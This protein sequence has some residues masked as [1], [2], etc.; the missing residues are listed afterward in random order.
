ME[1]LKKIKE[2]EVVQ[3]QSQINM[4]R[5]SLIAKDQE[6]KEFKANLEQEYERRSM[7]MIQESKAQN[8]DENLEKELHELR[9]K[10]TELEK[11]IFKK[12]KDIEYLVRENKSLS[13]E[14]GLKAGFIETMQLESCAAIED[15]KS[16]VKVL[17]GK[18]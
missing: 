10:F 8:P 15:E 1:H 16:K 17:M 3:Q 9:G 11:D 18:N 12:T 6:F 5:D 13:G 7:K 4:L 2:E 14:L